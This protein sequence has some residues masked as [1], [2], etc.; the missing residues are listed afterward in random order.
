ME[1]FGCCLSV[2][3]FVPEI[4]DENDSI[5]SSIKKELLIIEKNN[6]DF[7]EMSASTLSKL[8]K[9]DFKKLKKFLE[10]KHISIPV[11]NCFIPEEIALTGNKVNNKKIDDYLTKV[12]KRVKEL[13]GKIIIFG[14]GKARSYPKGFSAK[15]ALNQIEIFLKKCD[16]YSEEKN[17][18][19]AIEPL[20]SN[21]SNIINTVKEA[22]KI[23][24]R[25]DLRN[26]KVLADS[27]HMYLEQEDLNILKE[28]GDNLLH[29]HISNYKRS[30]P[31]IIEDDKMDYNGFFSCLQDINY[32]GRI[33]IEC[34]FNTMEKE[35]KKALEFL[36]A[37]W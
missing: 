4:A 16:N 20:N 14:S 36:K 23:A 27:Y 31:G 37:F 30:A 15:K 33:S 13:G 5:V 22:N 8:S 29:V 11:F 28:V 1:G 19:I 25:L 2:G 34:N 9:S 18:K 26:I 24:E 21:E 7:A 6:F 32:A 3:S 35:S 17:L 10:K 12:M